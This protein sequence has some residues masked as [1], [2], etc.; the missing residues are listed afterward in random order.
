M[1]SARLAFF[2]NTIRAKDPTSE[3]VCLRHCNRASPD[4]EGAL[5]TKTYYTSTWVMVIPDIPVSEGI[6]SSDDLLNVDR[7]KL[8]AESLVFFKELLALTGL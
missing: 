6:R 1:V 8:E 4:P 3:R 5:G 2:R 7:S